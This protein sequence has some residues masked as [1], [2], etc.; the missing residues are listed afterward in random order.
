MKQASFATKVGSTA[1]VRRG[2][3][4]IL[5]HEPEIGAAMRTKGRF[6]F[7]SEAPSGSPAALALASELAQ[8]TRDGYYADLSAGIEA[9]LRKALRSANLRAAQRL[10]EVRAAP[11]LH[12]ACAV[13][14]GGEAYAARIGASQVFLVRHAR[15]FLPGEEPGELADFVHRTT[16]RQATSLGADPDLLPPIWRQKIETGDTLVLASGGLVEGLGAEALKS[17]VVSLHPRAAA[18]HLHNRFVAEGLTGSDA[19]LLVEMTHARGAAARVA[20]APAQVMTAEVSAAE[21]IRTGLDWVWRRR[22]RVA[23]GVRA[24]AAPATP[25]VVTKSVAIGLEP[26]PMRG[27]SLP[28]APDTARQRVARQRLLTTM[29]AAALL[30]I[31]IGIVGIVLRDYQANQVFADYRSVALGVEEDI[32]SARRLMTQQVPD[33]ERAKERLASAAERVEQLSRSAAAEEQ[34]L[35]AFRTEIANLV[36]RLSDVGIDLARIAAD[37]K[38]RQLAATGNGIYA[39]D[40]AAGRLW[41]IFGDPIETSVVLQKGQRSVGAPVAVAVIEDV[42]YAIDDQRRVWKAEGN[43][44]VEVTP[45][46]SDRWKSV[47]GFAMFVGNLYVL[48]SVSGQLWKHEPDRAGRFGAAVPFIATPLAPNAAR[49]VAVDGDVWIVTVTGEVLRLRRQ[50][51]ATAASRLDFTARWEGEPARPA[52]IQALES[53]SSLYLLDAEGRRVVRMTRDGRETARFALPAD[54]P[55]AAAFYVSE[56]REL[57]YTVHGGKLAVTSISR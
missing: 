8:L 15:L 13:F 17:A 36:D 1:D 40:P 21:T 5:V 57:A 50:G 3:D 16:T 9:S 43:A 2:S 24:T 47:T 19:V 30:V 23:T 25:T 4:V 6:Y 12:C 51:L 53:Q 49:S 45:P 28:R 11:L 32:A 14:V 20:S 33:R 44:V 18:E 56:G 54:L 48:D 31:S 22:P 42:V 52:A 55:P 37:A 27:A 35:A 29:F 46:D 39:A 26:V 38:P 10:K 41:R 34:R 7:L